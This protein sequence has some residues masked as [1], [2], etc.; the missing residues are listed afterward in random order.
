[1]IYRGCIVEFLK[2]QWAPEIRAENPYECSPCF[3]L[4]AGNEAVCVLVGPHSK[5]LDLREASAG[6]SVMF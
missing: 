3:L 4:F 1:M 2:C 6:R 5:L